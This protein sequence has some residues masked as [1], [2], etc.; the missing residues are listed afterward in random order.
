M[1]VVKNEL[2]SPIKMWT[3]GV[4]VEEA[5]IK[6][7]VNISMMPFIYKH[8]AVMPDVHFG[9]GATV[10][11]VIATQGAII[12]AAVGVDIGC[13]MNA[14]R[15][16]LRA[17]DL[18]DSLAELRSAIEA[19]VPVGRGQWQD[20]PTAYFEAFARGGLAQ[21]YDEVVEVLG[22][23]HKGVL[24]QL[25]TLGGGNHFVEVCLDTDGA[26]W[27]MLHSGSRGPGN[28]VGSIH[29]ERAR[30]LM[31][32]Y[33]INLPDKDLAYFPDGTK[34]YFD[35]VSA[36]SWAQDYAMLNRRL[37]FNA[38]IGA[39]KETL[40]LESLKTTFET[41]SCHHN[42]VAKENHFG[43]NVI[44]TR[45]GAVR[46][47]EGDIGI[48]P[49]SMGAKSFIVRGKG[50]K[51]S[52]ESCSHGAG[53]SMS[54]AE[55]RKRFTVEDHAKAT[56]GVECRKDAEVI[57]ETPMAYKDIDLVMEAQKDLVDILFTLKQVLCIKG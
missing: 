38:C 8:V 53:R 12:P 46:A 30:Q 18:P 44:V 55:A 21:H 47:R 37:M 1:K 57:D 27:L 29:I 34:E 51:D 32:K 26:V 24:N 16:N 13:G 50:N 40:G 28:K 43:A 5:A 33:F 41:V 7:L 4:Q 20:A 54:R 17:E 35:Y 19:V 9:V 31:A 45:K 15:L 48:I 3:D 49:G 14:T 23:S 10:G 6:Q 39:I 52:F 42:Y 25:G 22:E 11:S 36:V 56:E 2:G